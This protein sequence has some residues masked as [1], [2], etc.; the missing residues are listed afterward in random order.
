MTINDRF[1]MTLIKGNLVLRID[2]VY[3]L[4]LKCQE[5]NTRSLGLDANS[6]SY[7]LCT[8]VLNQKYIPLVV[9]IFRASYIKKR[10]S[11][12]QDKLPKFIEMLD[13]MPD[14]H[15]QI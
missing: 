14:F 8:G 5:Q 1:S 4:Q 7:L 6:I 2:K 10:A 9:N 3:P 12:I 15:F 13:Q 11:L